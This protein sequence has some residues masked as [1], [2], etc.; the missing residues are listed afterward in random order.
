MLSILIP[1]YNHDVR[2]LVVALAEQCQKCRIRYQILCFDDGSK[3][4][5]KKINRQLETIYGVSYLEF[6]HNMGRARI[7]NKLGF[8]AMY[9]QLL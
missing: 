8:N 2:K 4:R 1:I 7:R 3:E 9:D 5:Y 6:E